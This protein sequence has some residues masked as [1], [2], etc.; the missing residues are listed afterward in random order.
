MTDVVVDYTI[1][2][3]DYIWLW[4]ICEHEVRTYLQLLRSYIFLVKNV[5][6]EW[7]KEIAAWL[8]AALY[9]MLNLL[10]DTLTWRCW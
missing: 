1:Y 2:K 8:I 3:Y 6:M 5:A 7:T 4:L 10:G 9:K